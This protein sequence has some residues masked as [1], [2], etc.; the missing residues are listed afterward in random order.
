MSQN[1]MID[2]ASSALLVLSLVLL[3]CWYNREGLK[4]MVA[5]Q[6]RGLSFK[7][8]FDQGRGLKFRGGFNQG[9]GLNFRGKEG[10]LA[11]LEPVRSDR[12]P[13]KNRNLNDL[14]TAEL[15]SRRNTVNPRIGLHNTVSD[16]WGSVASIQMNANQLK[17]EGMIDG[18]ETQYTRDVLNMGSDVDSTLNEVN[19]D[20]YMLRMQDANQAASLTGMASKWTDTGA[21]ELMPGYGGYGMYAPTYATINT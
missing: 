6:G 13:T 11:S 10:Y 21:D 3:F 9:R 19:S 15:Y 7:Q 16:K 17:S 20:T 12:T 14:S 4:N 2:T 8:G 5:R 18:D 1:K